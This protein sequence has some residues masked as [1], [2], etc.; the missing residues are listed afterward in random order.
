MQQRKARQKLGVELV[1]LGVLG[2]VAAEVGG[3]LGRDHDDLRAPRHRVS[4]NR[5]PCVAG[6]L[7]H[8]CQASVGPDYVGEC[9][10]LRPGRVERSALLQQLAALVGQARPVLNPARKVDAQ[11]QLAHTHVLG[12]CLRSRRLRP[13][14]RSRSPG[15]PTKQ[16]SGSK[17]RPRVPN[18]ALAFP[19]RGPR[20]SAIKNEESGICP[21]RSHSQLGTKG[22]VSADRRKP[23]PS[24][25]GFVRNLWPEGSGERF[26]VSPACLNRRMATTQIHDVVE[27]LEKAN[28]NLEAD[29]LPVESAR[30]LLDEY[31]KAKK[32]ASYGE[33][34]LARRIDDA[35]VVAR[36]AGAPTRCSE[37]PAR[38]SRWTSRAPRLLR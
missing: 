28:A 3:L 16:G 35:A 13:S 2:V 6:R 19:P 10:E 36:A 29:L 12:S 22:P 1:G 20:A 30:E 4:G 33:A 17:A 38:G 15:H 7:E 24:T 21:L 32:L 34:V 5:C 26:S 23:T 37:D 31:A 18:R 14:D 25:N 11:H 8:H 9:V 27:G